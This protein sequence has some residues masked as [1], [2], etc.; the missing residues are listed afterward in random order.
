MSPDTLVR[1]IAKLSIDDNR[2]WLWTG[3]LNSRGYGRL[4]LAGKMALAHRLS[5]RHFHGEIP[6]DLVVDH[7]CNVKRCVNPMH[8]R[9][10]TNAENITRAV[11]RDACPNGHPYTDD[12][13]YVDGRSRKCRICVRARVNARHHRMRADTGSAVNQGNTPE[14]ASDGTTGMG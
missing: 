4:Y 1:F 12:N 2:C 3:Q 7:I 6:D 14:G 10:L 5:Y 9:L 13:V 8:L 11:H